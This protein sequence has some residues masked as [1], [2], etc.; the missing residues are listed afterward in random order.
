L[1]GKDCVLP[2]GHCEFPIEEREAAAQQVWQSAMGNEQSAMDNTPRG[3]DEKGLLTA[4]WSLRISDWGEGS[5]GST[6]LAI[7]N[8]Q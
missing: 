7:G 3:P 4:D 8:R 1:G 6:D 5:R 2:I